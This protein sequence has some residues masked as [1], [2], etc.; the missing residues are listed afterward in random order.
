MGFLGGRPVLGDPKCC[1]RHGMGRKATLGSLTRRLTVT[2]EMCCGA[3]K[4]QMCTRVLQDGFG[5]GLSWAPYLASGEGEGGGICGNLAPACEGILGRMQWDGSWWAWSTFELLD[6]VCHLDLICRPCVWTEWLTQAD[7]TNER[8]IERTANGQ[9]PKDGERERG[10]RRRLGRE[11]E[12][13]T[14]LWRSSRPSIGSARASSEGR[15]CV[16]R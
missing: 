2:K 6:L 12:R 11:R 15:E 16:W 8:G 10:R 5:F 1:K 13:E 14:P 3:R 4:K 7:W 9:E